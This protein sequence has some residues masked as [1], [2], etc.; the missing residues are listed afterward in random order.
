MFRGFTEQLPDA[1]HS[2]DF[3]SLYAS[4][5]GLKVIQP[6]SAVDAKGLLKSIRENNVIFLEN[7]IPYGKSLYEAEL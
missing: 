4:I 6:F 1:Q 2:Q 3:A 5:P 7:E